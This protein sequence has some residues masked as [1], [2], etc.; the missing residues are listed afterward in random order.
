MA[1]QLIL[2]NGLPASGK[3]WSGKS[4][5]VKDAL[6]G[7]HHGP[8]PAG[9]YLGGITVRPDWRRRHVD[10]GPNGLDLGTG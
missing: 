9:H 6:L 1:K 2:V 10:P 5:L 4:W 8:A 7:P 3:R